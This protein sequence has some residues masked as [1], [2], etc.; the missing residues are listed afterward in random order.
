MTMGS[1]PLSSG[2]L[3]KTGLLVYLVADISCYKSHRCLSW[4][5]AET[6]CMTEKGA[7]E[8]VMSR[9]N[10]LYSLVQVTWKKAFK[11]GAMYILWS[12]SLIC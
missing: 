6:S 8:E 12:I 5:R 4:G 7:K 10:N 3:V 9:I 2:D 1:S 11:K